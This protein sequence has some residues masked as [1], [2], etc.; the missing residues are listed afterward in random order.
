MQTK[1]MI[2]IKATMK[3]DIQA[4]TGLSVRNFNRAFKVALRKGVLFWHQKF[5]KKHFQRPAFAYYPEYTALNPGGPKKQP[6][7][8]TG[9][10]RGR[11]LAPKSDADISGSSNRVS[12]TMRYGRPPQYTEEELKLR[13]AKKMK[14][15]RITWKQ[16]EAKVYA[17]AGYSPAAKRLFNT[18]I[19]ATN[20]GEE[21]QIVKYLTRETLAETG[22]NK[23][24]K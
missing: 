13:I 12:L 9:T 6:L 14:S 10:L 5:A 17:G 1:E 20:Q 22:K 2:A 4:A 18:L 21:K 7:V 3:R 24:K 19:P 11:V 15:E 16:A 8:D 23:G